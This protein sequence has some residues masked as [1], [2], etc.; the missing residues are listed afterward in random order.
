MWLGSDG[1]Q[2]TARQAV[3]G[4]LGGGVIGEC[5]GGHLPSGTGYPGEGV[6]GS[7][8]LGYAVEVRSSPAFR[9]RPMGFTAPILARAF[10]DSMHPGWLFCPAVAEVP[11]GCFEPRSDAWSPGAAGVSFHCRGD[12]APHCTRGV[13]RCGMAWG[14]GS[15]IG[16]LGRVRGRV[17]NLGLIGR[18]LSPVC[19]F[20]RLIPG[21]PS[22][23]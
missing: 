6:R 12:R 7:P 19:W 18:P 2:G 3:G 17:D 11:G 8:G 13:G 9:S 23:E 1:W 5:P 14:E 21:L 10:S 15:S 4:W 16:L 22:S 20:T